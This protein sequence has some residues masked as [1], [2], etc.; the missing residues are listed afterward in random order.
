MP[1]VYAK[2][3]YCDHSMVNKKG[4][5]RWKTGEVLIQDALPELSIHDR[6]LLISGTCEHCWRNGSMND[7]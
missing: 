7:G 3:K 6:E 4:Y 1:I 2:N 5:A